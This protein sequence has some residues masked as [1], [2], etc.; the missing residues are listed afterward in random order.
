MPAEVLL[1]AIDFATGTTEKF[2][3]LLRGSV[4]GLVADDLQL[5]L[6]AL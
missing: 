4:V 5:P 6:A 1:D 3:R 2:N